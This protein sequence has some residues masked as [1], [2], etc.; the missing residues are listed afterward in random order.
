MV[1]NKIKT[2][3][4]MLITD[5]NALAAYTSKNRIWQGIASLEVTK[6][7]R[8]LFCFYSGGVKEEI[9]NYSMLVKSEDG[10]N[11]TEPI[12]VAY[13]E[14]SRCYDPCLWIDPTGR[15]WFTWSITPEEKLYAAVCDDPDADEL[16]FSEPFIVGEEVM[17][18]K[19]TVTR[20]GE[21]LFPISVWKE[22]FRKALSG[23]VDNDKSRLAYAYKSTDNGKSFVR[24]GGV[25]APERA[26]DEHII[27]EHRDGRLA[28]YIRTLYGIAVSYSTDGGESWSDAVDS[29]L[30]GPCSRF[31]IRRLRSGR[32]LL[33]N[34]V[35]FDGRNNL[36]ALLSE[37][38]GK[39]FPYKLL[40]DGRS[41]VSYPDLK[42]ADDGFIYVAYDRERGGFKKSLEEAEA[43]AREILYAKITEADILA[44]KLVTDG[45]SLANIVNKLGKFE[46]DPKILEGYNN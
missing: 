35:D 4:A 28:M 31:A 15:L 8:M 14:G 20:A 25:D 11:F 36:T 44:G 19:P 42:E 9:E 34:H 30:G 16:S 24:L 46:G 41:E 27:F 13:R 1:Y 22:N 12:A 26:Y 29:G 21:W 40:L 32:V 38:D 18:N 5:K 45:S 6:R 17:M 37:D 3:C 10:V 43:C 33:I 7:G 39:S 2:R 23:A